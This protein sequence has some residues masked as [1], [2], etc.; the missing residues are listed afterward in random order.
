MRKLLLVL[1][2]VPLCIACEKEEE[3]GEDILPQYHFINFVDESGQNLFETNQISTSEFKYGFSYG[4][5]SWE[6]LMAEK[7]SHVSYVEQTGLMPDEL[8]EVLENNEYLIVDEFQGERDKM[9][10]IDGVEY[11]FRLS[12]LKEGFFQNGSSLQY[13]TDTYDKYALYVHHIILEEY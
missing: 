1:L 5:R 12:P 2:F 11:T 13:S 8:S 3:P 6:E 10:S 7:E 4:M 9:I